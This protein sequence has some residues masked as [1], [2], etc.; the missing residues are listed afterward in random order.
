MPTVL[1][2][3][4]VDYPHT[5]RHNVHA[6]DPN[7]LTGVARLV[8]EKCARFTDRWIEQR[9]SPTG[10]LLFAI[11]VHGAHDEKH[12]CGR[13]VARKID[14]ETF[15]RALEMIRHGITPK[16]VVVYAG[17]SPDDTSYRQELERHA[18]RIGIAVE[19]LQIEG[20]ATAKGVRDLLHTL[21]GRCD[22]HGVL[23][24]TIRNAEIIT[25]IRGETL[26]SWKDPEYINSRHMGHVLFSEP[27][28]PIEAPSTAMSC[29]RLIHEALGS[30]LKGKLVCI[31][32]GS[33]V[34]GRPLSVLLNNDG[35]T[36]VVCNRYTG[37]Y[38]PAIARM[39]DVIVTA[40]GKI[41]VVDEQVMKPGVVIID[42]A[43]TRVGNSIVGDV[44]VTD[45]VHKLVSKITPVP[46]GVGPVTV[47][48]LLSAVVNLAKAHH[49]RS[50]TA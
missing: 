23:V 34:I 2:L 42:A 43:I 1:D 18:C 3:V 47:A 41:G 36:T 37:Q 44:Q 12:L 49:R 50:K 14:R 27:N 9:L 17:N 25:T 33:A 35:A 48:M 16:L 46:G 31:I 30:D 24:Q 20:E 26:S 15:D 4:D 19:S 5:A 11:V 7:T 8:W 28:Q 40:T 39:A 22:V 38:L 21:N 6:L 29:Q 10:E 45:A 13:Y 32:N